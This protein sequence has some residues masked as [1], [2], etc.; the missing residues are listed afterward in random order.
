MVT[1]VYLTNVRLNEWFGI[2][3]I[4]LRIRNCFDPVK[5]DILYLKIQEH[6]Q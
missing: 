3:S 5:A 6:L 4:D 2:K 1:Y